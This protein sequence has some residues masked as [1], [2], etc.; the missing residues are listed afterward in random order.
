MGPE[1]LPGP[2]VDPGH[3]EAVVPGAGVLAL[4]LRPRANPVSVCLPVLPAT[5]KRPA[6]VEVEPAPVH[7]GG[8]DGGA[9]GGRGRGGGGHGG[10]AGGGAHCSLPVCLCAG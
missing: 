4:A 10:H 3:L 8:G 7:A 9:G 5:A 6:I 2:S 1:D